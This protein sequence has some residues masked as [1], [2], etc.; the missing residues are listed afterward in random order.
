MSE[1]Q[2]GPLFLAGHWRQGSDSG[3]VRVE[4]PADQTEV[5]RVAIAGVKDV[6]TAVAEAQRA[7][8]LWAAT[9]TAERATVL[10][11]L[12]ELIERDRERLAAIVVSEVGKPITEARGE[13][14]GAAGFCRFFAGIATVHGGDILPS[15]RRDSEVW[16]R[17]E[18]VGVVGAIIP[19][20]F[21]LALTTRKLAPALV[22]GNAV[23]IKPAELTPLSALAVAEL[24]VEAGL[25]SGV[26]SV[27]PG[28]GS[29]VGAALV[30]TPGVG[31]ITMTGSVGA[32]RSIMRGAAERIIPVSLELGG[33]APFVVFDDADLDRAVEA[34]VA[35]RM[36]NNGQTCVCNERTLV[37]NSV[38]EEF[39][40][41]YVARLQQLTV[42]D[43]TLDSTDVGP[44]VSG[45][46]LENVERI[47]DAA[48]AAGATV[49]LGGSRLS[50]GIFDRG[51]WY[52]PTVLTG[53]AADSP[54]LREEIFG[55]VTP[56]V[57]FDDEAHAIS[58]AND[59]DFGLSSYLFTQDFSRIMRFTRA[60]QSGE[61]FVNRTGPEEVNGFHSG[62]GE[63][64][65]GGD[66]G[67]NGLSIYTRTQT[68]Y[69]G[70]GDTTDA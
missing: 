63:S 40:T 35:T 50:G 19:W 36:L 2:F 4:N 11:R 21:P 27:L 41:R 67:T 55:P 20:N 26:L 59:T 39:V 3:S 1:N 13:V 17:R 5:A 18:P 37:H 65:L 14:D 56:I 32:G 28:S 60:V 68:V 51:Y 12:A 44:K 31:L 46:E 49:E 15:A 48:V 42:G 16:I 43:P 64:G 54:A 57:P 62:W 7:Q 33:K 22:A 45:P 38:Y 47:V 6:E 66:D 61:V 58:I 69:A 34:A 23:V 70:W 24:A 30:S 29:I 10:Y 9:P 53:L 8:P 25:P 52:A